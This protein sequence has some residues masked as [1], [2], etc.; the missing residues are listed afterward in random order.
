MD[1]SKQGDSLEEQM[2]RLESL[3]RTD[4]LYSDPAFRNEDRPGSIDALC[5]IH[6]SLFNGLLPEAG[7]IRTCEVDNGINLRYIKAAYL[8]AVLPFI[9]EMP[10]DSLE[11][12]LEKFTETILLHPFADGNGRSI[13]A[14]LDQMLM[15]G[16]Q[17]RVKW[18]AIRYSDFLFAQKKEVREPDALSRLVSGNL[19][20]MSADVSTSFKL[21]DVVISYAD[22]AEMHIGRDERY[23]QMLHIAVPYPVNYL[24]IP[25]GESVEG[26]FIIEGKCVNV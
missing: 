14:W 23:G 16:L 5:R 22:T 20:P 21:R 10:Q 15:H 17:Q 18:E 13:R 19:V 1:N 6:Q 2:I 8:P 3:Q 4:R 12:I 7:R 24:Q 26:E 11:R 25:E 9:T